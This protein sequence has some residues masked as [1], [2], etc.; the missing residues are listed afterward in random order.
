[1]NRRRFLAALGA[2]A[3]ATLSNRPARAFSLWPDEGWWNPCLVPPLPQALARHDLVQAA[4]EGLDPARFR[5]GHVHLIGVGD[6]H[7][8]VTINPALTSL[9]HPIQYLQ[10]KF[11]L[12]ASCADQ[13][14][15]V[16]QA[17]LDR[18]RALQ[19]DFP[20]G[21]KLMLLAFDYFYDEQGRAAPE[22]SSYYTPN[23]YAQA[24]AAAEPARFD[25]IASVHPYREDCVEAL[26][27]AYAGGARAVKWLPSAMG[28]DPGSPRCD[29]FYAAMARLHLPLLTHAG[30][31]MAVHGA[32]A[33]AL[34]NPLK[35]RRA[36]DAGVRVIVAHC[37][38]LGRG[39][40]LDQ[41]TDAARVDNFALFARLM[42]EPAYAGRLFG[43]ISAVTQ[44]NRIGP[45]L[46]TLLTRT[47]WHPRLVHGSDYPLP[48]VMPLF[49]LRAM[50]ERGYISESAAPVLSTIRRFNP[51][52]FDFVLKRQLR[53]QGQGFAPVVFQEAR[54]FQR[55]TPA[56]PGAA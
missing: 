38:S 42:D 18:L 50:V 7:S 22:H 47:D 10:R 15:R 25:W 37:A 33:Q 26:E 19:D 41:G 52:L 31:E 44:V 12:N 1:L 29:R 2:G 54:V 23:V 27:Q 21:A 30:D 56:P 14:G 45:A 3:V 36:L 17:F 35:L 16:D 32:D 34:G 43:D 40:D 20:R 51:L 9:W 46:D 5:D 28:M 11:Y 55:D 53:F 4:W 24:V 13:P 48:A 6:G 8:G 49:S 39:V